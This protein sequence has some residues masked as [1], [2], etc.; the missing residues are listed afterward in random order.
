MKQVLDW[1]K[2]YQKYFEEMA[3]IPHGSHHEKQYSDYLVDFARKHGLKYKQYDIGNVIIYKEASAGYEDHPAVVIQAHMDMV[4]EKTPESAHDFEKDPLD[5]YVE[6]GWLHARGTTLGADDGTGVCYMLAILADEALAHPA[7]EC[8]FTVLEEIGLDGALALEPEDLKG[9][10]YINLDGGGGGVETVTTAAGGLRW[11]G[12]LKVHWADTE[13]QGYRLTVGGLAGGH[14]GGCIHMEKGN[15][16]KICARVLKELRKAGTVTLSAM[17]GGSKDNAIPRDCWAEFAADIEEE[18]LKN[19]VSAMEGQLREELRYSDN[20]LA[21]T[22]ERKSVAQV[23]SQEES[24]KLADLLFICPTGMR[25]KNMNI[26]DH[27]IASENLA[28]VKT[29]GQQVKVSVSMRSAFESYIQEMEEELEILGDLY[30]LSQEKTGRY[31]AWGY[32]EQSPLR[33]AMRE[34]VKRCTGKDLVEKAVHGGLECGVAKNKWPDMDIITMGP[35]AEAVHSPD[36]C[37]DLQSFD[38]CYKV[39]CDLLAHL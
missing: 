3:S 19:V 31:P 13:K 16:I 5:L 11:N 32:E 36:E 6:D 33:E 14:S 28:V 20:G 39:L 10:R 34:T 27:T 23:W 21:I 7:L 8:V 2:A 30:G 29:A 25:H 9:R 1:S 37:L 4:C 38:D 35:T 15:A 12:I 24:D 17:D 18:K 22:L 26:K